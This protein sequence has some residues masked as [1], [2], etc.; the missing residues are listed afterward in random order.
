MMEAIPM[1][2]EHFLDLLDQRGIIPPTDVEFLREQ[3]AATETPYHPVFIARRLVQSG[4]INPY[5]AKTLLSDLAEL[6]RELSIAEDEVETPAT[7]LTT[8]RPTPPPCEGGAVV[9]LQD[10]KLPAMERFDLLSAN[11]NEGQLLPSARQKGLA[12]WLGGN[13]Q[14][15]LRRSGYQKYLLPACLLLAAAVAMLVIYLAASS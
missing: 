10:M 4:H 7:P 9:E 14:L 15:H 3:V 5:F 13:E 12:A 1:N 11:F 8:E 2:A 6:A